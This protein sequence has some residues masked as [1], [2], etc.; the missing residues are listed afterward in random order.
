MVNIVEIDLNEDLDALFER[1]RENARPKIYPGADESRVSARYGQ[2]G[3]AGWSP[4]PDVLLFS[5]SR[6]KIKG[7][8]LVVLLNLMAHYYVKNEMPFIRPTTIAKRMGVSQRTVQRSLARI[9]KLGLLWK[10]KHKELGHLTYDLT[11]LIEKLQPLGD[12]RIAEKKLR[13]EQKRSEAQLERAPGY[14]SRF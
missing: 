14:D 13:Q 6:L 5:Q 9:F 10:G 1:A 4:I 12:E 2:A 3:N 7:D 8:D 11:P